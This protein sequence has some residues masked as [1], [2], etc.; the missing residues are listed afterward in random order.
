MDDARERLKESD[1]SMFGDIDG[2]LA[3]TPGD[4]DA[5]MKAIKELNRC[6]DNKVNP[7]KLTI[8]QK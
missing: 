6:M 2:I 1:L 4:I 5:H 3:T 7:L 8:S